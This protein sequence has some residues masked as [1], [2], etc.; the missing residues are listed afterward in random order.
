MP[1]VPFY[2]GTTATIAHSPL[3]GTNTGTTPCAQKS[4]P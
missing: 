3:D 2:E 1:C 4:R